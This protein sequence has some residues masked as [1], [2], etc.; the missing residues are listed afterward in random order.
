[1]YD[2]GPVDEEVAQ[3]ARDQQHPTWQAPTE[4]LT[5]TPQP[6]TAP[7]IESVLGLSKRQIDLINNRD[8][9]PPQTGAA[10]ER[11]LE[12]IYRDISAINN[13]LPYM[14][15][16]RGFMSTMPHDDNEGLVEALA[17]ADLQLRKFIAE[18]DAKLS[19]LET[20]LALKKTIV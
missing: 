16:V 18:V 17:M 19:S 9:P 6:Y 1:M 7:M 15:Q 13:F 12:T 8:N 4:E 10:R 3:N 2:G 11:R 20:E 14:D 5:I